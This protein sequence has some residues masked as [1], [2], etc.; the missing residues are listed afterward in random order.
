MRLK[1]QLLC[2]T[3]E[4]QIYSILKCIQERAVHRGQHWMVN[5]ENQFWRSCRSASTNVS[6]QKDYLKIWTPGEAKKNEVYLY[7]QTEN[8]ERDDW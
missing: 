7:Q 3:E 2:R 8:V 6:V 5:C 1:Y 4:F